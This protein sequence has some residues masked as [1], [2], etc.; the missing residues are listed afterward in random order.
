MITF[1]RLKF[2]NGT[3]A[4]LEHCI[5][6]YLT[7]EKLRTFPRKIH[8]FLYVKPKFFALQFV[9]PHENTKV[10][11]IWSKWPYIYPQCILKRLSLCV[12]ITFTSQFFRLL[13]LRV[14][15][16]ALNP[17]NFILLVKKIASARHKNLK[18]LSIFV[19]DISW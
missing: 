16:C 10:K 1:F 2:L 9:F 6:F 19:L 18:N 13:D 3:N 7:L 4:I 17:E 12:G 5:F 14:S 11:L 15:F 8:K